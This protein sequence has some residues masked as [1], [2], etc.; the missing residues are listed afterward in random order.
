MPLT[1]LP[2]TSGHYIS[3]SLPISAQECTNWYVNIPQVE[4]ARTPENL[5]GT[6][7]YVQQAVVGDPDLITNANR[8]SKRFKDRP[9]F[10]QGGS[11]HRLESDFATTSLGTIEG[12]GRV[13]M[14]ENGLQLMILV[15]GGKGYIFTD[16]PD[17][18]TEITD[19]DFIANGTPLQVVYIDGYFCCTTNE[20]KFIISAL[21]D[22]LAWDALDFGTAESS[23]D[24]VVSPVVSKNQ[25]FICGDISTEGFTNIGGAGFPFQRSGLFLDHGVFAPFS[26]VQAN[27]TFMFIGGREAESPAIWQLVDTRMEKVSTTAIDTILQGFTLAEVQSAFAYT[28]AQ[29]GGYFIAFNLPTTTVVYDQVTGRWHERR[30]RIVRPDSTVVDERLRVNSV[31]G[32]YGRLFVGDSQ[33]GRIGEMDPGVYTE[34]G[35]SVIRTVASRPYHA[36]E[37][38]FTLPLLELTME[39]GVGNIAVP[40]PKVRMDISTDG[41]RTF[42]DDRTRSI[43]KAGEYGRRTVWRRNGRPSRS[44]VVRFTLSDAVKPVIIGLKGDIRPT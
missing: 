14:A 36:L 17:T 40:D 43:G 12:I 34:Y 21:N 5:F 35:D 9:Y 1:P 29:K 38:P 6:P 19:P 39:S 3:E 33:D 24:P 30:S 37:K 2:I 16:D 32:S 18:L 44:A 15:P 4:G 7:G 23:P 25:L 22:G 13:S 42:R 26:V 31:V 11:L 20:K 41:G 8:G 27:D 28:Y 10:V